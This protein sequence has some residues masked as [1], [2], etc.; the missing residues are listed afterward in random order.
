MR[1]PLAA[2]ITHPTNRLVPSRPGYDLDYDRLFALAAE[3][4][5]LVEIDGAPGHLD[6]DG[7]LARRAVTAGAML[8]VSSDCHR[9]AVLERQMRLG[10][11]LA[12]R[13]WVEPRHVV[14]TQPVEEVRARIA[15]KRAGR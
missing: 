9:A 13:G 6:L 1:H 4:Q 15:R 10:V 7:A 14:N 8:A 5:T 12:R 2:M 3:T 11:L